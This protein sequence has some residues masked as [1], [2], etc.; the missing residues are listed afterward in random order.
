[1]YCFQFNVFLLTTKG[2][3]ER[4]HTATAIPFIPFLGIAR[5]QPQFPHSCVL[6]RF[7]FPESVY[8]FPPTEQA[9]P[10]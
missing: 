5:P 9:D 2:S 3:S 1:M 6:E 10:S 4:L 7:I 8:I